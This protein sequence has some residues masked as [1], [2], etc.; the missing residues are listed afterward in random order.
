[1]PLAVLLTAFGPSFA[2]E[3]DLGSMDNEQL[4]AL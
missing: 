1:M 4:T 2:Q 3:M